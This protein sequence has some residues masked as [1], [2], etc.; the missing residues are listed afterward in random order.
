[1]TDEAK[2]K[3]RKKPVKPED[4]DSTLTAAA[5]AIGAAAGK[6]AVMAGIAEPAPKPQTK[7]TKPAKQPKLQSKNKSRLPRKQKKAMQK[8]AAA[9]SQA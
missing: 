1:M 2:P 9:Q 6:V 5:K 8:K 4:T 3:G 7:S